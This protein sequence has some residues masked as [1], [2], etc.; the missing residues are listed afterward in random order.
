MRLDSHQHFW[1][2]NPTD[3][4]W[5]TDVMDVL[6]RDYLPEQLAAE[7]NTTGFAGTIAV[8]A[9]Q[10]VEETEWLLELAARHDLIRGV[11]G[12]VDFASEQLDEQLA[13]FS[14]Y[15]QL[16]GVREL[17][18]DM[19]NVRYAVS[20]AHIAAIGKLAQYGLTYDLLL[21]PPHLRPAI[22]LVRQFPDQ[23]FVVDHIAKPDIASR[24]LSPWQEDLR[25]LAKA[26]NVFCKLSGMV[27]EARW[28]DW[29]AEDFRPYLDVVLE[30]FGPERLMIGSDWPV[31]LL[32]GVYADVM[33][34]VIDYCDALSPS[35][36]DAILGET[37]VR[38]YGV[39][40]A[41]PSK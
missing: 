3:Y 30:A 16:K 37:A 23:P 18:H 24:S 36:Q 41:V 38:F 34:I 39:N 20:D 14:A 22:E 6:R 40:N 7:L 4:V 19:P 5:M 8:Q 29:Q 2:Y 21:K 12:W 1:R 35:E 13:R 28:G 17:I 10:M 11:V 27:T 25:E 15:P 33:A 31:C 9:R 32:S 26:Q